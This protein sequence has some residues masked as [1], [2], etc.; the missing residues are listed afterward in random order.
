MEDFEK[1]E[2]EDFEIVL[3][4]HQFKNYAHNNKD[5]TFYNLSY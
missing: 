4:P 5:K 1:L 3:T 2:E